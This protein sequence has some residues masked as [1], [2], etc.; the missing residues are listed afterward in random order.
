MGR[1]KG[2]D[3]GAVGERRWLGGG[4]CDE[5]GGS[6]EWRGGEGRRGR[7]KEAKEGEKRQWGVLRG[8]AVDLQD[9]SREGAV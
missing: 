7:R 9:E 2:W 3:G 4:G 6:R 5:V 8:G 1:G